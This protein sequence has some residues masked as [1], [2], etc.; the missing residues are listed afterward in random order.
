MAYYDSSKRDHKGVQ[1][2]P[3]MQ[4][5]CEDASTNEDQGWLMF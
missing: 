5:Y 2:L 4:N 3:H 1:C